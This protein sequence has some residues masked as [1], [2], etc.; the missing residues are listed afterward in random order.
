MLM[1]A[2]LPEEVGCVAGVAGM[3]V[4]QA[5]KDEAAIPKTAGVVPTALVVEGVT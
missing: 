4:A 2:T 5:A 3:K 1:E